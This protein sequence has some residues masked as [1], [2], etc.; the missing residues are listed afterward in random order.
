[1]ELWQALLFLGIVFSI[2]IALFA[3]SLLTR[4]RS[5][6]KRL[7]E[8]NSLIREALLNPS[9]SEVE[10]ILERPIPPSLKKLYQREDIICA[11]DFYFLD[12]IEDD[13]AWSIRSFLPLNPETVRHRWPCCPDACFFAE[14]G[15]CFYY[16]Q[17]DSN[18]LTPAPVFVL[19]CNTGE[20]TKVSESLTDFLNWPRISA[21]LYHKHHG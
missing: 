18:P 10:K 8:N 17:L 14:T 21:T 7:S 13:A 5:M 3:Y 15:F 2:P 1:M 6:R 16:V 12:P 4:K 20:I 19:N 11:T 9:F